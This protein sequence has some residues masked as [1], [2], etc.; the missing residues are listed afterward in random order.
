MKEMD[1]DKKLAKSDLDRLESEAKE[2][3]LRAKV[4]RSRKRE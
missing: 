1:L 2:K 3:A 4:M